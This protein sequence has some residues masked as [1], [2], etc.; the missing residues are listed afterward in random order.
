VA[1][2]LSAEWIGELDA[3]AVTVDADVT[4]TLDQVVTGGPGG[5]VRYRLALTGGRLAVSA[6]RDDDPAA[7]A[8]L[9]VPFATAV[10]LA[11][12]TC[13]ASEAFDAGR[14][15]FSGDLA[16]LQAATTALTAVGEAFARVRARTTFSGA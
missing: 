15:R 9:T 16:R 3:E 11:R 4:F 12:G 2:F 14:V 5:D 7:D 8:T 6:R 1:A 10:D 13:N